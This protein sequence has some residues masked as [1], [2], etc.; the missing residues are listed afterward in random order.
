[1]NSNQMEKSLGNGFLLHM[2]S[3]D[4]GYTQYFILLQDSSNYL[5]KYLLGKKI[6]ILNYLMVNEGL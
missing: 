2:Y 3:V 1:M 5:T 6:P 4:F